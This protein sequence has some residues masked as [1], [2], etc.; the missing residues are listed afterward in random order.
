MTVGPNKPQAVACRQLPVSGAAFV[1]VHQLTAQK[2][3]QLLTLAHGG[4]GVAP[5]ALIIGRM[6]MH[7][8]LAA[9][10]PAC[11]DND[12]PSPHVEHRCADPA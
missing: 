12:A 11:R 3:A 9:G 5:H 1:Q 2:R 10:E 8:R 4:D 6:L 7:E